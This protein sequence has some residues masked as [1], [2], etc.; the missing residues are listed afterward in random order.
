MTI[1]THSDS[2]SIVTG[3][4]GKRPESNADQMMTE[5]E[6]WQDIFTEF[7]TSEEYQLSTTHQTVHPC[8][9]E[10]H[11]ITSNIQHLETLLKHAPKTHYRLKLIQYAHSTQS[12]KPWR[13]LIHELFPNADREAQVLRGLGEKSKYFRPGGSSLTF[14]GH[15]HCESVLTCLYSL[16]KHNEDISWVSNY[17]YLP[18]QV[19]FPR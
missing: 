9:R 10:L 12:L 1:D 2:V 16:L 6:D 13:E 7:E 18:P 19:K 14:T 11:L 17:D 15:A 3:Q 4:E 8:I 5:H